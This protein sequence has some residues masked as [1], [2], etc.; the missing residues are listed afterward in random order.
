MNRSKLNNMLRE[1][2]WHSFIFKW[3]DPGVAAIFVAVAFMCLLGYCNGSH[4]GNDDN[5]YEEKAEEMI[6]H[7]TG[8]ELDLTPSSKE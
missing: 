1:T 7:H 6:K 4:R 2:K 8:L 3:V 5:P